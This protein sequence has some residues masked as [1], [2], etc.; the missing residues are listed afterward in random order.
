MFADQTMSRVELTMYKIFH[1]NIS[2]R[3]IFQE[4]LAE[5]GLFFKNVTTQIE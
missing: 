4:N 1:N 5:F 2:S 3:T